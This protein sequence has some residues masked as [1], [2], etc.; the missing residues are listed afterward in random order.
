MLVAN[1]QSKS[2]NTDFARSL[3]PIF[4]AESQGLLVC[5]QGPE[6]KAAQGWRDGYLLQSGLGLHAVAS[7]RHQFTEASR[8][9]VT[10]LLCPVEP[11]A[12]ISSPRRNAAE[13][14]GRAKGV[15]HAEMPI[16][17]CLDLTTEFLGEIC[18]TKH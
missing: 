4:Q 12:S 13:M 2:G 14:F 1:F 9:T 18:S 17:Q 15:G 8:L 3:A 16:R 6:A 7:R 5:S 10:D 11:R